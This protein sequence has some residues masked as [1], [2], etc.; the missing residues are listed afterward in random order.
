MQYYGRHAPISYPVYISSSIIYVQTMLV[1]HIITTFTQ[2]HPGS[3]RQQ[4]YPSTSLLVHHSPSTAYGPA[5]QSPSNHGTS[6]GFFSLA[7][8]PWLQTW[9]NGSLTV[10]NPSESYT[11]VYL[12]N[13][14]TVF[15]FVT[16]QVF[17]TVGGK[18]WE[19]YVAKTSESPKIIHDT[20]A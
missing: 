7:R 8:D 9:P 4:P 16:S 13:I 5:L 18:H 3:L 14:S 6:T 11:G 10:S 2:L 17:V 19:N 1:L 20:T 15:E 12:C